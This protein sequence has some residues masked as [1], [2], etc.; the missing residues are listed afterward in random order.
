MAEKVI[1]QKNYLNQSR[2]RN[3]IKGTTI[4]TITNINIPQ[5][6]MDMVINA[7]NI[8]YNLT[9]SVSY[10]SLSLCRHFIIFTPPLLPPSAN[11]S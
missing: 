5:D 8:L 7:S 6:M 11:S 1:S 10:I 4:T 2:N 9:S 3:V